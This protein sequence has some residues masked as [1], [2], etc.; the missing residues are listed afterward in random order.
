[1]WGFKYQ[2]KGKLYRK[3]KLAIQKLANNLPD[4]PPPIDL[5]KYVQSLIREEG[6]N[7]ERARNY[8]LQY[9]FYKDM[10]DDKE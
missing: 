9:A 4:L 5:D 6:E 2:K 1:M 8:V 7:M 10:L 3:G